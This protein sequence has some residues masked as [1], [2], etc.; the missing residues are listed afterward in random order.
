MPAAVALP[1]IIAGASAG[2]SIWS[3]SSKRG[4]AKTAASKQAEAAYG[5]SEDYWKT[6]SDVNN[7][8]A[9]AGAFA[10]H[11]V[12]EASNNAATGVLDAQQSADR[13]VTESAEKAN[14]YLHPYMQ[15]GAQGTGRLDEVT[16]K[17][18]RYESM[19][20]EKFAFDPASDPS[21]QFVLDQGMK[22]IQKSA[23]ARGGLQGG[24]T[25]RSL[26]KFAAGHASKEYAN[27]FDRFQTDRNNRGKLLGDMT[28][29]LQGVADRGFRS[30]AVA[31]D[32]DMDAATYGGNTGMQAQQYA[33]DTHVRSAQYSGNT[34]MTTQQQM[35]R[36]SLDSSMYTGNNRIGVGNG[37]AA[38]TMYGANQ[39]ANGVTNALP[40]A[41]Q[42]YLLGSTLRPGRGVTP[43]APGVDNTTIRPGDDIYKP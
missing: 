11:S 3:G 13:R 31:G 23:A 10:Q 30:S 6:T 24:G 33:G 38:S 42:G 41:M 1:F 18:G 40:S 2:G 14:A 37:Q 25:L 26:T 32:N 7:G 35:A 4:A 17:G 28:H 22:A 27:Q 36:N 43:G 20:D 29:N 16:G 19:M 34:R 15:S 5:A 12:E 8:L 39:F 21:Y 9:D